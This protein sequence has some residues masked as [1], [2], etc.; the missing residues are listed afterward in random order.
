MKIQAAVIFGGRSVEHEVSIITGMQVFAALDREKYDPVPLYIA[1]D[2]VMYSGEEFGRIESYRQMTKLLSDARQV[3]VTREGGRFLLRPT[4]KKLF[5]ADR[6]AAIDVAIPAVHGTFTEDGSLQGF[7]ELMGIPYTGCDV[8]SSAVCMDKPVAKAL[9]RARGISVLPDRVI[10][11]E[12]YES[13]PDAAVARLETAWEDRE[14]YPVVVKPANLGSS[15]GIS[16]ADSRA[17]L[18]KA[19]ELAFSYSSRVLIEPAVQPLREI[20]VSVLGEGSSARASVCEEPIGSDEILSYQDKYQSG[21]KAAKNAGMS[22]ARRVIPAEIPDETAQSARGMALR[23]F[24]ALGCAG[25]VRVDFLLDGK[26]GGLYVN[27]LN[28]LPGSM[29]FYF[30]EKTGLTFA[31]MLDEMISL[32]FARQ[33]ERGNMTFSYS[34]NLLSTAEFGTKGE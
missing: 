27:E 14:F 26:N 28:T 34:T 3:S 24:S 33:R 23:A 18:T 9:L 4:A 25:V 1:K 21:G 5:G 7:L 29:A 12:E 31:A 30:W 32:A 11:K 2:G 15:V 10:G 20:N 19:M 6:P 16:K 13:D 8:L 22:S 17:K